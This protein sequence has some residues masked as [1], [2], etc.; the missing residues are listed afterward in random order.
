[1]L[2]LMLPVC[3]AQDLEPRLYSNLPVDLN[4][5][6]VG[7]AYSEGDVATDPSA[8]LTNAEIEVHSPIVAYARSLDIFGMSGKIDVV[9]PSACLSGTAEVNGEPRERDICGLADP[10]FRIA[11]N[12]Y[13][14]PALAM[15]DFLHYE[16]ELILGASLQVSAP[17]GQYNPDKLVNIGTNRWM[18]KPE[19]GGSQTWGP[20]SFELSAAAAIFTDNDAFFG[21]SEREQAPIYSLQAHLVYGLRSGIWAALDGTLYRGGRTKVDG[22]L[23]D[24]LQ[25]NQRLGLTL[26]FPVNRK[27]SIKL[28]AS[29]GLYTRTG[30]DF[31]LIGIAWQY[32]WGAGL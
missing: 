15:Q 25:E 32:R 6:I 26:A 19:L 8:P 27:H 17:L 29:T 31:D 12:F 3:S 9:A 23:K 10:R 21:D 11:T 20:F 2:F 28:Y 13:G 18:V 16:P 14:A 4:F 30:S 22:A 1:M 24:D 5:L 7:Y